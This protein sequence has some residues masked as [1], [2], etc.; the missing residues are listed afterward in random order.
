MLFCFLLASIE[1]NIENASEKVVVASKELKI[2]KKNKVRYFSFFFHQ[3][4]AK[5]IKG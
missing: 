2:T 1:S 5:D 3:L 4:N